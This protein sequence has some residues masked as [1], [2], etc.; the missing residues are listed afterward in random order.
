MAPGRREPT[1]TLHGLTP[2]RHYPSLT[3]MDGLQSEAGGWPS[4]AGGRGFAQVDVFGEHPGGG[5]PV[6][7]VIDGEGLDD[8]GMQAFAAWT[9]LSETTFLLAPTTPGADYRLRIFTPHR[10]LPF[11]GHPTLGSAHAW[12]ERGLHGLW[13]GA[14]DVLDS[15]WV[16]NGPGW[17]GVLLLNAEAVLAIEPDAAVLAGLEVNVIGAHPD[18]APEEFEVRRLRHRQQRHLRRPR[19]RQP[20]RQPGPV[21]HHHRSGPRV[22]PRPATH[23]APQTGVVHVEEVDN[24]LWVG[25]ATTT[26]I[27][28]TLTL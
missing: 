28:G 18:G 24:D 19:H 15:Q 6:A 26:L 14:G 5:N 22:L 13:I 21:A 25:G 20:Q 23:P 10:E 8:A 11:A 4:T 17:V 3:V 12:L 9:N 2:A 27:S 7:V 16:D 1:L